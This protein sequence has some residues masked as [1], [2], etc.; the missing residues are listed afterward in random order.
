MFYLSSYLYY[1]SLQGE[2][3]VYSLYIH[4]N[5]LGE[6]VILK[7]YRVGSILEDK[8][9]LSIANIDY[10]RPALVRIY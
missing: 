7:Y 1:F 8:I 5:I 2:S 4:C 9:I 10:T 3:L 6:I